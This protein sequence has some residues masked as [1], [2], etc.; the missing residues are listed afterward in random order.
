MLLERGL[1]WGDPQDPELVV[2]ITTRYH[3]SRG[4]EAAS[5]QTPS[6]LQSTLDHRGLVRSSAPGFLLLRSLGLTG[7]AGEWRLHRFA[8]Y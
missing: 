3:R 1:E 8:A 5:W 7:R 4:P 2:A 6:W